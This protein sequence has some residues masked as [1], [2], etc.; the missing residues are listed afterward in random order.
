MYVEKIKKYLK[1]I[2]EQFFEVL[3]DM[4]NFWGNNKIYFISTII[5]FYISFKILGGTIET[6]FNLIII[7]LVTIFIAFSP[8]GENY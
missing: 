4:L 3:D 7:Y 8:T 1:L 2:T 5:Y 6:F